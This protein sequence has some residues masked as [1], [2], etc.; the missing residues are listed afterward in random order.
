[1]T[2]RAEIPPDQVRIV[3]DGPR[4]LSGLKLYTPVDPEMATVDI[5]SSDDDW[6][7]LWSADEQR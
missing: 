6:V 2:E 1:M 4:D 5:P 7:E 3:T